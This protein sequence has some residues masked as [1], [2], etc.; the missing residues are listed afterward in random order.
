[1]IKYYKFGFGRVS[2]YCNEEIRLGKMT[3][4]EAEKILDSQ[5]PG[6]FILR[7]SGPHLVLSY[8]KIY[9][10]HV[11]VQHTQFTHVRVDKYLFEKEHKT[12]EEIFDLIKSTTFNY[13]YKSFPVIFKRTKSKEQHKE[14]YIPVVQVNQQPIT[15]YTERNPQQLRNIPQNSLSVNVCYNCKKNTD[16]PLIYR[17]G[18]HIHKSCFDKRMTQ[19]NY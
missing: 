8:N 4:D 7:I 18:N 14:A 9:E 3:R 19:F 10:N 15:V 13:T 16:E 5:R 17:A 12:R 2:D 11:T 1:M 6:A